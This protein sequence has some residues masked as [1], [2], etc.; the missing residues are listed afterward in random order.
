MRGG[1]ADPEPAARIN[2][3]KI[4]VVIL[5]DVREVGVRGLQLEDLFRFGGDESRSFAN[6]PCP[7][8]PSR[9]E[10]GNDPVVLPVL[11]QL[12]APVTGH[13]GNGDM[14]EIVDLGKEIPRSREF[15]EDLLLIPARIGPAMDPV[16][17]SVAAWSTVKEIYGADDFSFLG[18]ID[19][20][21]IVHSTAGKGFHVAAPDRRGPDAGSLAFIENGP[22]IRIGNGMSL[23][24]MTPVDSPVRVEERTMNVGGV[25][26]EIETRSQFFPDL[27]NS[28][29]VFIGK[30]PQAGR[31]HHVEGVVDP[32]GPLG[33]GELVGEGGCLVIN[34]VAI[35]IFE[36]TNRIRRFGEKLFLFQVH[37][38][39][40]GDEESAPVI[41]RC[42]DRVP[43]QPGLDGGT[44]LEVGSN[45]EL[46]CRQV[47]QHEGDRKRE[48]ITHHCCE[49]A[50]ATPGPQGG[51][52]G[53]I[54][55]GGVFPW[56]GSRTIRQ[57]L[58]TR[59]SHQRRKVRCPRMP[60]RRQ[61]AGRSRHRG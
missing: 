6:E 60:H 52:A 37:S 50:R 24:T 23:A 48:E 43:D 31:G 11:A 45:F 61:G 1:A 53:E 59:Q 10:V 9:V 5:E 36:E 26:G 49:D 47:G 8:Q 3:E 38:R 18:E 2:R 4:P 19:F 51:I 57:W 7:G 12:A 46:P 34:A 32:E 21:G 13:A 58:R 15:L 44:N 40:L 41:E 54:K 16:G 17:E 27:G 35:G 29:P 22:G 20:H 30:T 25:P 42:H 33:K 39:V 28:V 56:R 55:R 14:T